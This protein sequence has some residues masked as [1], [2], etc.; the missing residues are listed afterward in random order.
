[1]QILYFEIVKKLYIHSINAYF[2][3]NSVENFVTK[4]KQGC[5]VH[6]IEHKTRDTK[7]N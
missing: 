5:D 4:Y 2:N 6:Y 7:I 1:M 3:P